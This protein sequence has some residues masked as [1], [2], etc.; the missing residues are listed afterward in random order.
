[1]VNDQRLVKQRANDRD[2]GAMMMSHDGK[3]DDYNRT[4]DGSTTSRWPAGMRGVR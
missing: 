2:D 1:M 3:Y 4:R